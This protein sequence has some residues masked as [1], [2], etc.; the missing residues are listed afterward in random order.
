MESLGFWPVMLSL[1]GLVVGLRVLAGWLWRALGYSPQ[2][3]GWL[4]RVPGPSR[5]WDAVSARFPRL[6]DWI[7]RRVEPYRF[8]GL[9][10]TLM[11][12]L[13]IYLLMLG[14]GLLEDLFEDEELTA[15]DEDF[16]SALALIRDPRVLL[17]FGWITGLGGT[18]T[19]VAISLVTIG[20]LWAHG[21]TMFIPGLLLSIAGSQSVTWAGKFLIAR[22]RPEFLTFAEA[23]SPSFPSAHATGAMAVY[24]FI[25]Y[26]IGR[27]LSRMDRRFELWFW[28]STLILLVAAS[29]MILSVHYAS[30]VA[31]GLLVGGFWLIAGFALTEY[32][33]HRDRSPAG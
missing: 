31:A 21:R 25:A 6:S 23:Y 28:A 5:L 30:D 27:D 2:V 26:A 1:I 4:G 14:G 15:L 18:E 32:L 22:E 17:V 24:G 8:P 11:L 29:R 20:F 16:N 13:S 10:L 7:V 12:L 33:R 9:P 3:V 19:L